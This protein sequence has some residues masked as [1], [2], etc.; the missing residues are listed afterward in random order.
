MLKLVNLKKLKED[1]PEVS[2]RMVLPEGLDVNRV[3]L[4]VIL[5]SNAAQVIIDCYCACCIRNGIT[6]LHLVFQGKKKCPNNF[7]NFFWPKIGQLLWKDLS[8]VWGVGAF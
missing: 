2:T 6:P 4:P 3:T 5:T 8:E 7:L 1:Y